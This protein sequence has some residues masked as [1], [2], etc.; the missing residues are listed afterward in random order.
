MRTYSAAIERCPQT[1]PFAGFVPGRPGAHAQ[2]ATLDEPTR[3]QVLAM[4][5]TPT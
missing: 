5:A 3:N 1:G 4:P 2:G